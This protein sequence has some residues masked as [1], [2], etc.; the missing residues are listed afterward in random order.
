VDLPDGLTP[1]FQTTPL[2]VDNV[3]YVTGFNGNAWAIDAR[4]GRQIWRYRRNMPDDFRGCCGPNNR[5]MAV[6]GDK[7]FLGTGD[8]HI[9]AL[10]IKTATWFGMPRWLSIRTDIR[11][12][13]PRSW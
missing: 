6:L 13:W 9:V 2:L 3:L 1:N 4:T 8:A 7:L 11:S 12:R 5:G 10:D